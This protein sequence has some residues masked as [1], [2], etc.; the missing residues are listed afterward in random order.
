MTAIELEFRRREEIDRTRGKGAFRV[1]VE[2]ECARA[3]MIPMRELTDDPE[4]L[5][6]CAYLC[7]RQSWEF[8]R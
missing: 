7:T 3:H 1:M 8:Y 2:A 4:I 5:R 6:Q